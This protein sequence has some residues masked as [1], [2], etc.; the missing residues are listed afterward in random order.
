MP[1]VASA[2][3]MHPPP[4]LFCLAHL[5]ADQAGQYPDAPAILAPG[6]TPLTYGRLWQ[7]VN[8]VVQ[9][10]HA[11]GVN[12]HDRIALALPNGPEMAVA[13]VA[14]AAGATCAPL[15]PAYGPYEY[16]ASLAALNPKV[17]IVQA[18]TDSS[19][20]AIARTRG[21]SILELSPR[22]DAEAGLFRLT[23]ETH[24]R[25]ELPA[26]ARPDDVALV[27]QT[28]GTTSQPKT[29]PLTHTNICVSAYATGTALALTASD[30]CLNVLPLFHAHGLL[31]ALLASLAA[32]ASVVCTAGFS[33][34]QFFAWMAEFRPTWSTAVP[35]LYQAILE[36]VALHREIIAGSSLRLLRS[37]SAALPPSLHAALE[38]AFGVPVLGAYGTTET[39]SQI[40]CNPLPPHVRKV[41]SV[42]VAAGPEVAIMDAEGARLPAGRSARSSCAAPASCKATTTIPWPTGVLSAM[43]G[44]GRAT[45]GLWT[46]MAIYSSLVASRNSSTVVGRKLPLW[47]WMMYSWRI[48]PSRRR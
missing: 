27:L 23:G 38:R 29:V 32:G 33:A 18:G 17:L 2:A 12:R 48:L 42:G 28:A 14:V 15:H 5:L 43:A 7:H 10:L 44:S 35:A 30:R 47:K 45:R 31:T 24:P 22:L 25:A 39:S 9:T 46:P 19:A 26:F 16:H 40:A 6:R 3:Q 21:I 8:D 37:S 4:Q 20:R 34:P 41:G 36:H 1:V 13:V 11:M